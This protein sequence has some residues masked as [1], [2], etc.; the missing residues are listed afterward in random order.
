MGQAI[1][2]LNGFY[3]VISIEPVAIRHRDGPG[4]I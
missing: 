2:E 3:G 4:N 1:Y